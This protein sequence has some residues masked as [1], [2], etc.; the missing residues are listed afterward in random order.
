VVNLYDNPDFSGEPVNVL[1]SNTNMLDAISFA[2]GIRAIEI[3]D[4]PDLPMTPQ[5][6]QP[7]NQYDLSPTV[8][9][10]VILEWNSDSNVSQYSW[11]LSGPDG[12]FLQSE[13]ELV[14]SYNAG[15]L[16]QGEYLFL[17]T[18]ENVI[19]T[20]QSSIHFTVRPIDEASQTVLQAIPEQ[21]ASTAIELKWDIPYGVEDLAAIEVQYKI[22]DG[23][24]QDWQRNISAQMRNAWFIGEPGNSYAFRMRSIDLS[25]NVEEY[26]EEAEAFTTIEEQCVADEYEAGEDSSSLVQASLMEIN[27]TQIHNICGPADEDWITF[28]AN[29][30]ESLQISSTPISGAAAVILQVYR[31]DRYTKV[32]E[33]YPT[34]LNEKSTM[35]MK[36]DSDGVYYLRV[37]PLDQKVYGTDA[38]YELSITRTGEKPAP[39]FVLPAIALPFVWFM[40]KI[41]SS[42]KVRKKKE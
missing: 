12:F 22:N 37:I 11:E 31:S 15:H 10:E 16:A 36:V 5:I 21:T 42:V 41:A 32:A 19:G 3:L 13:P 18:A 34:S 23:E 9:D 27:D 38:R 39:S 2:D 14:N 28:P 35:N 1:K 4:K 30:G 20:T 40:I 8:E 24:W 6:S 25:E 7:R 17:L 33:V 29:E 26:P